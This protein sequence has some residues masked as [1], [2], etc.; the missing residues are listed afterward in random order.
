LVGFQTTFNAK[1]SSVC[2]TP[3]F[4][5]ILEALLLLFLLIVISAFVSGSA[6]RF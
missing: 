5:N 3:F 6:N 4:M 1:M 2:H